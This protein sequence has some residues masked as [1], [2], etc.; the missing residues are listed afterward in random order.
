M[1]FN[2]TYTIKGPAGTVRAPNTQNPVECENLASLLANVASNLPGGPGALIEVTGI[3][4]EA[5][6][7]PYNHAAELKE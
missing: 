1:R 5:V 2:I 4:V 7:C 3:Q 6:D